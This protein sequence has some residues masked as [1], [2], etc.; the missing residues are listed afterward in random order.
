MSFWNR[1]FKP[2]SIF[3]GSPY[4]DLAENVGLLLLAAREKR[5][6]SL[7]HSERLGE[8]LGLLWRSDTAASSA[9]RTAFNSIAKTSHEYMETLSRRLR[10]V[11]HVPPTIPKSR[12]EAVVEALREDVNANRLQPRPFPQRV[13]SKEQGKHILV[14]HL[15]RNITFVRRHFRRK[16]SQNVRKV[17]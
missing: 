12:Y 9:V 6:D 1:L 7:R 8:L 13:I 3:A 16:R 15:P 10:R 14:G 4:H 17:A 11:Y 2:K 5:D